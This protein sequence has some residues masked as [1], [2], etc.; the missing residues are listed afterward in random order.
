MAWYQIVHAV[1]DDY[2]ADRDAE[3]LM[4]R[5]SAALREAEGPVDVAVFYGHTP[6]GARRYYLSLSPEACALVHRVLESYEATPL[7]A[8]PELTGMQQI[9]R[10]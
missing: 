7:A 9:R 10:R 3:E 8:P 1:S 4:H 2:V 6:A 5:V